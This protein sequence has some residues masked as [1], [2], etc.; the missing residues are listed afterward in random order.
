MYWKEKSGVGYPGKAL[1]HESI[2]RAL[3]NFITFVIFP[4]LSKL[5]IPKPPSVVN[6]Y[7]SSLVMQKALAEGSIHSNYLACDFCSRK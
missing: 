4:F 5:S 3:S 1:R 6:N 7:G 2:I